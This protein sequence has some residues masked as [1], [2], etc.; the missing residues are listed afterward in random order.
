[1]DDFYFTVQI[2]KQSVAESDSGFDVS[3]F[4]QFHDHRWL[5]KSFL[6]N[7]APAGETIKGT[8]W[9]DDEFIPEDFEKPPLGLS[10]L[11]IQ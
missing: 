2:V 4:V 8:C 5:D 10:P 9:I 3:D 6:G 1:L 7:Q 11:C